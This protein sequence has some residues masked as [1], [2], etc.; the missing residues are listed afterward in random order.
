MYLL[1]LLCLV[2]KG[3]RTC[4][5]VAALGKPALK[6]TLGTWG[7]WRVPEGKSCGPWPVWKSLLRAP[8]WHGAEKGKPVSP[9][10]ANVQR[11][12][13]TEVA[14]SR[15]LLAAAGVT[16]DF[17]TVDQQDPTATNQIIT[18]KS[19][20][21]AALVKEPLKRFLEINKTLIIITGD[22]FEHLARVTMFPTWQYEEMA[23]ADQ[24][25]CGSQT[26]VD[27]MYEVLDT[28]TEGRLNDDFNA[29]RVGNM[30]RIAILSW[31]T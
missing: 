4:A 14:K 20:Q 31:P 25:I 24:L 18:L 3:V 9:Q 10:I 5:E 26:V 29:P 7:Y 13:G 1:L 6:V 8:L 23:R 15:V 30:L 17:K 21:I 2:A 19:A 11:L 22:I 27:N 16:G 28:E 12:L